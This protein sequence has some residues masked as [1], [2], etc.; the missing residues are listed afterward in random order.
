M[1]NSCKPEIA[2]YLVACDR[3]LQSQIA[4]MDHVQTRLVMPLPGNT[5]QWKALKSWHAELQRETGKP[6]AIEFATASP[7]R[8]TEK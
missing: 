5:E 8:D 3:A 2:A 7:I 1:I 6:I 4:E